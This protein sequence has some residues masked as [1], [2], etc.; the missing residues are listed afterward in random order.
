MSV[1]TYARG[2]SPKLILF[3]FTRVREYDRRPNQIIRAPS[4]PARSRTLFLILDSVG[5]AL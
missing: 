3:R 1:A 5:S 2:T 4:S